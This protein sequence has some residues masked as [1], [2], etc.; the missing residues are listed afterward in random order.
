MRPDPYADRDI[1]ETY[2]RAQAVTDAHNALAAL[3][4]LTRDEI[5]ARF[6]EPAPKRASSTTRR[7]TARS[8]K[9]ASTPVPRPAGGTL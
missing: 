4:A 9:A 6:A 8:R 5:L 3:P 7:S 1:G 2:F